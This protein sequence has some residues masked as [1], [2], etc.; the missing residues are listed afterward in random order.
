MKIMDLYKILDELR[1]QL[2]LEYLFI[3][4]ISIILIISL[5]FPLIGIEFDYASDVTR[6]YQ[7]KAELSQLANGIN[8]VYATGSG[9]KRTIFVNIPEDIEINIYSQN[10]KGFIQTEIILS[11]N[12]TK[13]IIV[14]SKK[15]NIN[16]NLFLYKGFNKVVIQWDD[17]SSNI[18]VYRI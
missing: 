13:E 5:I 7:I 8:Y 3:F 17:N 2:S 18:N 12:N 1:G 14:E 15:T 10:N 11:D 6:S 4:I 9:S 16:S